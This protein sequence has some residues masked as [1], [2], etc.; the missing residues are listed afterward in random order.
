MSENNYPAGF[1]FNLP[2]EKA[3]EF[4]KGSGV[5]QRDVFI[6]WLQ[7]QQ[8]NEKG[9]VRLQFKVGRE[10]KGY[11]SLDTYGLQGSTSPRASQEVTG[12]K[13]SDYISAEDVP[14]D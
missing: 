6:K 13:E 11:A 2:H 8:T 3:P 5:I 4:V 1:F 9:Q 10:G 7:E 12:T 14:F